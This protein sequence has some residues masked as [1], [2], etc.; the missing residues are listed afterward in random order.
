MKPSF[1]SEPDGK[2]SG[3]P[4]RPR[5]FGGSRL[6][7]PL[8]LLFG[9]ALAGCDAPDPALVVHKNVVHVPPA[10]LFN[11]PLTPLPQSFSSNQEVAQ[12]LNSTYGNN[13]VC[14]NNMNA[15]RNDL[16]AQAK[17]FK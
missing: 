1:P 6:I 5:K 9:L 12:T 15:L 2:P 11:C 7:G 4:I 10:A 13:V 16:N 3:D 14:H 8:V 17:A